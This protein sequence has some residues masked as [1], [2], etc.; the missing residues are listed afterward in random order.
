MTTLL[1][2]TL[3]GEIFGTGQA[4]R[5]EVKLRHCFLTVRE[6]VFIKYD[7][8]S[9]PLTVGY[10]ADKVRFGPELMFGWALGDAFASQ[11]DEPIYL[12]KTAWGG[13]DLAVNFR[14]PRS[15]EG[16]YSGVRPSQYGQN[17]R[18][19][20]E[21][22]EQGLEAIASII[23]G[24]NETIGYQISGFCWFQGWN[25]MIDEAK[26]DEYAYNLANLM[27]DVAAEWQSPEI[28]IIVGEL[29]MHGLNYTGRGAGRVNGMR[30][31]EREVPAL[32]EFRSHALFVPTAQYAVLNGTTY[33]GDY[34]YYGRADT[35]YHIGKAMGEGMVKLLWR[36][37][38]LKKLRGSV[39]SEYRMGV[40]TLLKS[41][42]GFSKTR[43][44]GI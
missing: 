22:V 21:G 40:E 25:D 12:I 34:H 38:R 42:G 31:A 8:R 35:Y 43:W 37:Q 20:V 33:N 17:Y 39:G 10:G 27:R 23:P 26:V 28:P 3:I 41:L 24:Y 36:S 18:D 5:R 2:A 19:M 1:V 16:G 4:T 14:P 30:Q 29:G 32:P 6:D 11:A 7:S 15:G 13:R 9:G 44:C